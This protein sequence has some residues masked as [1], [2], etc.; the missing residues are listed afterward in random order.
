MLDRGHTLRK[1]D[2]LR[3]EYVQKTSIESL[4]SERLI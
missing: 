1:L 4:I 3:N 2:R